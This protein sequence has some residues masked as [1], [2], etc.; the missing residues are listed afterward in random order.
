M[1]ARNTVDFLQYLTYLTNT[2]NTSMLKTTIQV[3]L[4]FINRVV[5]FFFFFSIM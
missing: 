1:T 5:L 2:F 3:R 4:V